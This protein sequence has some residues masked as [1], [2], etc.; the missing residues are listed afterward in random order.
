MARIS[1]HSSAETK[2]ALKDAFIELYRVK[3]INKITIAELVGAANVNRSTFYSYFDDIYDLLSQVEQDFI[4]YIQ[5][6][7]PDILSGILNRNFNHHLTAIIDFYQKNHKEIILFLVDKP[8]PKVIQTIKN[9]AQEY[10][11]NSV[12]LSP[13]NITLHQR[14]IIEYIANAQLGLIS[15]WLEKGKEYSVEELGHLITKLNLEGPL[16]TL[17]KSME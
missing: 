7:F 12:G 8:N 15:W 17:F 16:P 4:S 11:L 13:Q 9:Y 3:P 6:T 14:L 1:N 2:E 10:A 5:N